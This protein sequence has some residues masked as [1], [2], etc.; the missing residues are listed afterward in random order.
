MSST[1]PVDLLFAD[2][3]KLGPGDDA[4]TLLVLNRLPAR[5]LDLI[6]DAGCGTGRQTLALAQALRRRMHAIDCHAP[7]LKDLARRADE[8]GLGPLIETHC[9]DMKDIPAVFRDIDLLWSEGA[10]Y[11]IGFANALATWA[12][13]MSDGGFAVVSEMAWLRDTVPEAVREF[14]AAAYPGMQEIGE[15]I[16]A[17]Q[18][19]GY[20]VLD[21]YTLPGEAWVEGYYDILAPRAKALADHA[22]SDVAD[23]ARATLEEIEIFRISEGSYGYV[24]YTL[25]RG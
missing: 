9:M 23:F 20:A 24:F 5:R 16:A 8:A 18:E 14:F 21:T 10:A 19:A 15:N 4:Q 7:F 2:M 6:V 22:D 1:D 17:A 12:P 11:N 25:Q 13:A 3:A